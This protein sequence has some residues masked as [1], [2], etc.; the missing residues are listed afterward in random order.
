LCL[1]SILGGGITSG[2]NLNVFPDTSP[3]EETVATGQAFLDQG[4]YAEAEDFLVGATQKSDCNWSPVIWFQR[5]IVKNASKDTAGQEQCEKEA[6]KRA[7]SLETQML[8]SHPQDIQESD[9]AI[10]KWMQ[11]GY[12]YGEFASVRNPQ[13]AIAAYR[14]AHTIAPNKPEVLNS[15]GYALANLGENR[16]DYEEAAN[17]TAKAIEINRNAISQPMYKDSYGW[18]LLKRNQ[19]DDLSNAAYYLAEA[20]EGAPDFPEIH[21]HL[22]TAQAMQKQYESAGIS[23]ERALLLRPDYPEAKALRDT[24]TPFLPTAKSNRDSKSS[25]NSKPS[26][27]QDTSGT[28]VAPKAITEQPQTQAVKDKGN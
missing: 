18:A 22:A 23:L 15:L 28:I 21:Y 20:R 13:K 3:V 19:K 1:G 25:L 6:R 12:Y 2:C 5:A 14:K 9:K 26:T 17:L 16:K 24:I 4:K 27:L 11:L 7:E 8:Q 10:V